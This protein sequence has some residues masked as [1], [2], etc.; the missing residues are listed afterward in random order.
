M[1]GSLSSDRLFFISSLV[2]LASFVLSSGL[3][4]LWPL[5]VDA[6]AAAAQSTAN[7]LGQVSWVLSVAGLVTFVLGLVARR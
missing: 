3:N 5:P 1:K 2:F 7:T 4:Y 6:A